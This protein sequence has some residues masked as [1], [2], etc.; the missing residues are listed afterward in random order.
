M[1]KL[2]NFLVERVTSQ[3]GVEFHELQFLWFELFVACRRVAGRGFALFPRLGA[4]NSDDFPGHISF[5]FFNRFL[6]RF[7]VVAFD[8]VDADRI[9][10]SEGS[11]TALAQGTF[12]LELSLG[13]Y[14]ES[15]PR[16]SL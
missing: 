7:V 13:L 12:A 16:D 8:F 14:C 10:C 4:F 2:L 11:K 15:S 3:R 9:D 5:F 6:F 1:I